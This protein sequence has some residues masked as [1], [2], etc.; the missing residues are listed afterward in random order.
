MYYAH[1]NGDIIR[2]DIFCGYKD[3]YRYNFVKILQQ[4]GNYNTIIED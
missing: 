4:R 2:E 1:D 3:N